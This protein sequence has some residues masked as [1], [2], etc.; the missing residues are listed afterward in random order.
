MFGHKRTA[1]FAT[2]GRNNP[3]PKQATALKERNITG[4]GRVGAASG[5][6]EGGFQAG[7]GLL[8]AGVRVAVTAVAAVQGVEPDP[9]R[10]EEA[11]GLVK[12][13]GGDVYG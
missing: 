12:L 10:R 1:C 4:G 9:R 8:A 3:Y 5:I 6:R 11:V 7:R 2:D 13:G